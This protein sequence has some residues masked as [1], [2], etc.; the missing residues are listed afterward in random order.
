MSVKGRL[1]GS[2]WTHFHLDISESEVKESLLKMARQVFPSPEC[3]LWGVIKPPSHGT[4]A[5]M[6]SLGLLLQCY[7]GIVAL[8]LKLSL[9]QP[10]KDSNVS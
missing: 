9:L 5:Q 8:T 2:H 10:P 1:T 4:L 7:M 6:D 3:N